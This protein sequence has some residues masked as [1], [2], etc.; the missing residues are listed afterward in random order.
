MNDP[1]HTDDFERQVADVAQRV[2]GPP[3]TV[4]ALAITRQASTHPPKRRFPSVFSALK[5]ATASAIIALVGAFLVSGILP[6]GSPDEVVPGAQTDEPATERVTGWVDTF[7]TDRPAFETRMVITLLDASND[8]ADPV[9]LGEFVLEAAD[10]LDAHSFGIE[11]DPHQIDE[12]GTYTVDMRVEHSA[13]GLVISKAEAP[14]PVITH[15]HPT[16]DVVIKLVL[17]DDPGAIGLVAG[18][19]MV[20]A[21]V[22]D[23]EA[24]A[25]L[26]VAMVDGAAE[27]GT[28]PL[29]EWAAAGI[30]RLRPPRSFALS[31]D[32]EEAEESGTYLLQ[33]RLEDAE[34]GAL[35]AA[36]SQAIADLAD[37]GSVTIRLS[38]PA[39]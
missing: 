13:S 37:A 9:P 3:R 17:V 5:L 16:E 15:G 29:G 22:T 33:A 18:T 28:A 38:A 25:H 21:S 27:A 12:D 6:S 1:M 34:T 14:V 24:P 31:Y 8:D 23:P 11:Y 36:G 26:V 19:V 2:V 7:G 35:L 20:D 10:R 30:T 32:P 4:D 39:E